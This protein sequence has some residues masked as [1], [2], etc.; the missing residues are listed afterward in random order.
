[1]DFIS[2]V[3][4]PE[5]D[6]HI[7]FLTIHPRTRSTPSTVPINLEALELLTSTYGDKLPILVSGDV[8]TLN[9]LP[10]TSP[11]LLPPTIST[12]TEPQQSE[13][14]ANLA[15]ATSVP[16]Q[17]ETM[18]T[19]KLI[20]L[21]KL[22]GLMS[23]RAILANPAL[24]AGY[25]ACPWEAVEL[26]LNK[27]IQNPLPFKLVQHHVNEMV[28]PGLGPNKNSLL[29]KKERKKMLECSNMCDLLDFM[30]EKISSRRGTDGV[31]RIGE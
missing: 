8:F 1:M 28:S 23:A 15:G 17:E 9:T 6:R 3:L 27:A 11:L 18:G 2:T 22:A 7:D 21:P 29:G 4:G 26:F 31:T 19:R 10:Y 25:D 24:F 20:D 12:I 16:Q 5:N 13:T 14:S 30:D